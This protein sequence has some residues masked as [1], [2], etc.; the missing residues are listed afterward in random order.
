MQE[1]QIMTDY[2]AAEFFIAQNSSVSS[3]TNQ[4]RLS[5]AKEITQKL[6]QLIVTNGFIIRVYAYNTI[7]S[8]KWYSDEVAVSERGFVYFYMPPIV[9]GIVFLTQSEELYFEPNRDAIRIRA[10]RYLS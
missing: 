5:K 9:G 3:D 4:V 7:G 1:T 2:C 10:D 8:D 6:S